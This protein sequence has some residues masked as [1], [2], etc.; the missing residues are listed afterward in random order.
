MTL[1]EVDGCVF[2]SKRSRAEGDKRTEILPTRERV[3]TESCRDSLRPA[4][5]LPSQVPARSLPSH[6]LRGMPLFFF[7]P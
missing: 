3:P 1:V 2:D 5:A 7:C 6:P 4:L